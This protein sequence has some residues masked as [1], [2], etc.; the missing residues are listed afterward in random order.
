MSDIGNDGSFRRED[1]LFR[2]EYAVDAELLHEPAFLRDG[3]VGAARHRTGM[4]HGPRQLVLPASNHASHERLG[5][6][7]VS[8]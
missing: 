4:T 6:L 7:T 5:E 2:R 1:R 8:S 3:I